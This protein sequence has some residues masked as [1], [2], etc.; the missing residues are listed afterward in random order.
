MKIIIFISAALLVLSSC[1]APRINSVNDLQ[2]AWISRS[3]QSLY[4]EFGRR[5]YYEF[6][7]KEDSFFVEIGVIDDATDVSYKPFRSKGIYKISEDRLIM[8]GVAK[9]E[10]ATKFNLDYR[11]IFSYDYSTNYLSLQSMNRWNLAYYDMIRRSPI[12]K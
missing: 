6:I 10:G 2:G 5:V 3:D 7:F 9:A 8:T 4:P 12:I 11:E 1:S